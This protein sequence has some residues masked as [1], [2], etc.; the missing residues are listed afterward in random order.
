MS[1]PKADLHTINTYIKFG[2]NPL[3]CTQV[4]VLKGKNTDIFAGR[5]LCQQQTKLEFVF[6][7]KHGSLHPFGVILYSTFSEHL[8]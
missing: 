5:Q 8:F 4:I 3:R 2:E 1:T 7:Q 6:L